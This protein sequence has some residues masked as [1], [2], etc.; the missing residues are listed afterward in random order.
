MLIVMHP[1]ATSDDVKSVVNRVD[2][3]GF[4]AKVLPGAQRTAVAITGNPGAVSPD[5]FQSLGGVKQ[6]LRVSAP[7]KLVS[8][9]V[10]PDPTIIT[11]P[12]GVKLGGG[13]FQVMAG[14]CSVESREQIL[15]TAHAV[16]AAGA[17]FLRGGA[18]KP[19]TSPYAFQGLKQEGLKLLAEARDATGLL[20]I[21][22]V[23]DTETL[24]QVA[25]TTDVL[26]IG[27][28]NMQNFSLLEAAGRSQKPVML[29]RGMSATIKELLMAAEYVMNAGNEQVI[30][31]E[32]GIRT[33]ETMT[34]NTF[35]VGAIHMLKHLSHLPVVGDPS[36]GIGIW[37]G[38]PSVARAALVAGADGLIIEVHPKPADAMS[39]GPQSLKPKRFNKLMA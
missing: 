25:D 8:R 11:F 35:D 38:V 10:S 14:P 12:N 9:E 2:S 15:E 1:D 24:S 30:L 17:T 29:K 22:E 21:T 18:Y 26:Q 6:V 16:K 31:C 19:R 39:D 27:A 36:H 3:L 34:R 32:R 13:N 37:H 7:Y 28:R 20:V 33:F 23:K 4:N 5:L